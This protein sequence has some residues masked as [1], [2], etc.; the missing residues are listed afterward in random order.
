MTI[1]FFSRLFCPHIGGVEKHVYQISKELIK[2]GHKVIIVTEQLPITHMQLAKK[3]EIF[4]GIEIY[5]IEMPNW[6]LKNNGIGR[7]FKKFFI[8]WWLL[9]NIS[10]IVNADIVHAHDVFYWYLPFRF[11][12]PFKKIYTTFHGYETKF[13]PTIKARIVRKISERLSN[14]NICVGAFIKKW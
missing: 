7:W 13:P 11:L 1:L 3:H 6:V 5:R 8:W 2:K 4:E 10:I 9:K 12:F 14:G